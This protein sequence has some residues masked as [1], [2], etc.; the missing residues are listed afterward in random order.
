MGAHLAPP[1]REKSKKHPQKSRSATTGKRRVEQ[2]GEKREKSHR[3]IDTAGGV[4]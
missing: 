2:A 4:G 1:R 3:G